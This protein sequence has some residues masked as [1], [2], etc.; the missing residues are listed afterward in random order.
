MR[1]EVFYRGLAVFTEMVQRSA[2]LIGEFV[3]L[4]DMPGVT[5]ILSHHG[6]T[7]VIMNGLGHIFFSRLLTRAVRW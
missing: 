1:S 2:S 6:L 3:V 7:Q 5:P 4:R